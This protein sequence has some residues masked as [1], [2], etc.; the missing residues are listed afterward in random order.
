MIQDNETNLLYLADC[1]PKKQP[2]FFHEF[3]QLLKDNIIAYKFIPDT[4]DIWAVDFMPVQL[5]I[6]NFVRF[7]YNP[8]YLQTPA[9]LK[10]ISDVSATLQKMGLL[11]KVSKILLDGGNVIKAK[12][13]V[14]LSSRV[15]SE[16][17]GINL[18]DLIKKLEAALE[19]NRIIFIPEDKNDF[20]GHADGMVRLV[21]EDTVLINKYSKRDEELRL[22]IRLALHNAGLKPIEFAYNPYLN[23]KI[24]DAKGVY[25]NYLEMDKLIMVPAFE[26][27]EDEIAVKQLEHLFPHKKV[28]SINCSEIAKKGGVLN[29][30]SWNIK[31]SN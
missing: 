11:T 14:I 8:G 18:A 20:T 22:A 17:P 23:Y 7:I 24:D 6:N 31:V 28:L 25:I 15:F 19:V 26:I 29:C 5:E 27:A 12:D 3:E 30:V 13:K 9:N 16:N 1:L 10:T 2:V 4:K 21:D